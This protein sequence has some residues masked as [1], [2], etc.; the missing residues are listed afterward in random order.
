MGYTT[1]QIIN[2]FNS[3]VDLYRL[4][5]Y[6]E[7]PNH[8]LFYCSNIIR[9]VSLHY[10]NITLKI[11]LCSNSLD[12]IK[13]LNYK[14]YYYDI[15]IETFIGNKHESIETIS[16]FYKLDSDY[17]VTDIE[18]VKKCRNLRYSRLLNNTYMPVCHYIRSDR[19]SDN[20]KSFLSKKIDLYLDKFNRTHDYRIDNVYFSKIKNCHKL[21]AIIK[22]NDSS[23]T[24]AIY[25]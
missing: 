10:N 14:I 7:E 16:R 18:E 9:L 15:L 2:Y 4:T 12:K 19:L 17:F 23:K 24:E 1:N 6:S 11:S 22:H 21:V 13:G 8:R 5:G 25:F 20:I 3:I